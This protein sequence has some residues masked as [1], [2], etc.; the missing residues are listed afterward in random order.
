MT[1]A[2]LTRCLEG[3]G[4]GAIT[5]APDV[6]A[7]LTDYL[8]RRDQWGRV[9][10]LSGPAA[11]RTP[12]ETDVVDAY[13]TMA[14]LGAGATL[15]DVG[16]G[17][18]VPGLLVACIDP[19]QPVRLVE[20]LVKRT[21]FLRATAQALGLG[22]VTVHR[23]RWPLTAAEAQRI[24]PG[25]VWQVISRA[26]VS[27]ESW[28]ALAA[29]GGGAVRSV[30]RMLAAQRPSLTLPGFALAASVDYQVQGHGRR[31]ERWDRVQA[32]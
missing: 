13:A 2:D 23:D 32:G 3:A 18:G 7:R 12:W 25:E 31:I 24:P 19:A 11:L 1:S 8:A 15:V 14:V 22:G 6:H 16:T 30:F 5:V 4:L 9:H 26:V 28:P 27:P 17:S 29:S 10:N 20:P 21:A